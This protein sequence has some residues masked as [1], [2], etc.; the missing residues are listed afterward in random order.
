MAVKIVDGLTG[1]ALA[2][3]RCGCQW[4]ADYQQTSATSSNARC[5]R[6]GHRLATCSGAPI[7]HA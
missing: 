2:C 3:E 4:W 6:C 1:Q 7:R 5:S